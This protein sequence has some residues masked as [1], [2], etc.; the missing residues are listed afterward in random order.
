MSVGR[1]ISILVSVGREIHSRKHQPMQHHHWISKATSIQHQYCT[2]QFSCRLEGGRNPKPRQHHHTCKFSCRLGR[3]NTSQAKPSQYIILV[4]LYVDWRD[5]SQGNTTQSSYLPV[6][7]S[8]PVGHLKPRQHQHTCFFSCQLYRIHPFLFWWDG[9][10]IQGNT[11]QC[12]TIIGYPRQHQNF[13]SQAKPFQHR[14][15]LK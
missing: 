8:V 6:I 11:N 1:E 15:K 5:R 4:T 2:C 13:V 10:S 7:V 12:N 9:R 14:R 3:S